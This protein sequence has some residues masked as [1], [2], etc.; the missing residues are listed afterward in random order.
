MEMTSNESLREALSKSDSNYRQLHNQ[1]K[2][3]ESRLDELN[4]LPHL[5]E[6]EIQEETLIKKKKLALKDEM[7]EIFRKHKNVNTH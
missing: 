3:C 7:E 2:K 5:T 1:H 4:A 6:E